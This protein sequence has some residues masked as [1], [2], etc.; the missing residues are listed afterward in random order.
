MSANRFSF[1]RPPTM[2]FIPR[3]HWGVSVPCA[4]APPQMKI[5]NAATGCYWTWSQIQGAGAHVPT[6]WVSNGLVFCPLHFLY[7]I[8]AIYFILHA[9]FGQPM[10]L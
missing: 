2:G 5:P 3:L 10:P 4:I 7:K 6:F 1:S 9:V 8:A